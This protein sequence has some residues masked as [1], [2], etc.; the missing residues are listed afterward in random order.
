MLRAITFDLWETLIFDDPK[1]DAPRREYRIR[2]I[3]RI[4]RDNGVKVAD[5][6]LDR[7]HREVFARMETYWS[8]K[9]DLSVLEQTKIFVEL[10]GA[11]DKALPPEALLEAARHY[12]D[13]AIKF[14]PRPAEGARAA[15]AAVRSAGYRLG[16]VCNTGRAPGRA[17][18]EILAQFELKS[19]FD[20]MCFSD[21]ARIRKPSVDF[22]ARA[23]SRLGVKPDEAAHVGDKPETDMAGARAAGMRT[24]HVRAD[25]A[26]A[27]APDLADFTITGVADLPGIL[28]K[29]AASL[30]P[31]PKGASRTAGSDTT[32]T[33]L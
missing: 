5:E 6:A 18:R 25:G 11:S 23:P 15:L 10:A 14:P 28:D 22:F 32:T 33:H 26:P 8:L 30:P 29:L 21:E 16:L 13:A 17:L 12:G 1:A 24:V 20:A 9:L 3:G 4:L 2:E 19:F 7:A 31:A 27:A